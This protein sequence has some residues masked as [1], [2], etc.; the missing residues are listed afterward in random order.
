MKKLALILL[1]GTAV[2]GAGA[3]LAKAARIYISETVRQLDLYE[4]RIE[5]ANQRKAERQIRLDEAVSDVLNFYAEVAAAIYAHPSRAIYEA[6]QTDAQRI[7]ILEAMDT[8]AVFLSEENAPAKALPIR[9][10]FVH[11]AYTN[12][13]AR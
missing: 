4:A 6:A 11:Q 2:V 5:E 9:M 1:V 7:Y 13:L 3:I 8:V 10:P 12:H